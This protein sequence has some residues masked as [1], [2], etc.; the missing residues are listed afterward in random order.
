M[1]RRHFLKASGFVGSASLLAIEADAQPGPAARIDLRRATVVVRPGDLPNAERTTATMFV[2]EIAKRCGI[3]LRIA[4]DWPASGP[5]IAITS[6]RQVPAWKRP[7]PVRPG[8]AETRAE[9]YRLYVEQAGA[10]PVIWIAGADARGTLF[11][12]GRL[13]RELDWTQGDVWLGAPIDIATAPAYP[14]RGHQLGYRAQANSYDAW[15]AAQFE[16]YIRELT[17][18]GINS[19]EGIPF[20]DERPTP[21]MKAGRREMNK[22]IGEICHRYGLDYWLWLPA[23]FDLHDTGKRTRLLDQ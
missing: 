14:I 9:G 3:R 17:F 12:A 5:V 1:N 23:E 18:F 4:S 11:G 10:S 7:V 21:V 15:D 20:Q 6:E 16:K 13:L 8:N 2:V 19:I 22:A